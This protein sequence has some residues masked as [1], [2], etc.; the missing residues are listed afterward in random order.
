VLAE[1]CDNGDVG[2][3]GLG[4]F[5]VAMGCTKS[6]STSTQ[7]QSPSSDEPSTPAKPAVAT[8]ID[9]GNYNACATMSDGTVRCWGGCSVAC[10]QGI[11]EEAGPVAAVAGL[12]GAVE[13]AVGSRFACARQSSGAVMCWG[14]NRY[15]SLGFANQAVRRASPTKVEGLPPVVELEATEHTVAART[16]DGSVWVWGW[17]LAPADRAPQVVA[18]AL[19]HRVEGVRAATELIATGPASYCARHDRG[20]SC[21]NGSEWWEGDDMR[22]SEHA[23]PGPDASVTRIGDCG[24][25]LSAAG[26]L[27]CESLGLPGPADVDGNRHAPKR[28]CSTELDDVTSFA[29][30]NASC[31][32]RTSGAVTCWGELP[33]P[34]TAPWEVEL[35]APAMQIAYGS[36]GATIVLDAN[37]SVWTWG[38]HGEGP[39]HLGPPDQ[40]PADPLKLL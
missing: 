40:S 26:H 38:G 15:R 35:P 6:G 36:L 4:L 16:N 29:I 10:E 21:W 1:P 27:V 8:Q 31:A 23:T 33:H 2:R 28:P 39:W 12:T 14:D 3:F 37:G 5:L 24:C 7:E 11:L 19:P 30:A 13:V 9:G 18:Q 20:W 32:I 22:W 34:R 25:T 17:T